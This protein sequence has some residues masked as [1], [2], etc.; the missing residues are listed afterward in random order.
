MGAWR[1]SDALIVLHQ[2][3]S[4]RQHLLDLVVVDKVFDDGFLSGF[5]GLGKTVFVATGKLGHRL[6]RDNAQVIAVK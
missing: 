6:F 4:D 2:V 1:V 5:L 3:L